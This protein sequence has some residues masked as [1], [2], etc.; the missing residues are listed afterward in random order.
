[1]TW[2]LGCTPSTYDV[3]LTTYYLLPTTSTYYLLPTTSTYYLLLTTYYLLLTGDGV[4]LDQVTLKERGFVD[5]ASLRALAL[6]LTISSI[7]LRLSQQTCDSQS[8]TRRHAFS[9]VVGAFALSTAVSPFKL[10]ILSPREMMIH[11][12]LDVQSSRSSPST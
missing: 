9:S 7:V 5:S 2:Q 1:M 4:R 12:I 8:L 6:P 11:L 3:L 10:P